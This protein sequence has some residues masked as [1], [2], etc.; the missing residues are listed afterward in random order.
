MHL[1]TEDRDTTISAHVHRTILQTHAVVSLT[2]VR[3]PGR[4]FVGIGFRERVAQLPGSGGG[5]ALFVIIPG[6]LVLQEM[7][8]AQLQCSS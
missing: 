8:N 5:V 1:R 4:F 3:K 6:I 2:T 7:E